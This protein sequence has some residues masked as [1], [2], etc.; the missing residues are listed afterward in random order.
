VT[1]QPIALAAV[2][3]PRC[4]IRVIDGTHV[5][6]NIPGGEGCVLEIGFQPLVAGEHEATLSLRTADDGSEFTGTLV[7]EASPTPTAIS[8]IEPEI[9][10]FANSGDMKPFRVENVGTAS[11]TIG[12][13]EPPPGFDVGEDDCSDPDTPLEPGEG[14]DFTVEFRGEGQ[15]GLLELDLTSEDGPVLGD[16]AV[17]LLVDNP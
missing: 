12:P 1:G 4:E 10:S 16:N 2:G 8:E 14:C 7:G 13:I 15:S 3:E 9:Q 11:F 6:A 5:E 17:V